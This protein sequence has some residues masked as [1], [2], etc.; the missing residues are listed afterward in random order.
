[1]FG[2]VPNA[3][4]ARLREREPM[5]TIRQASGVK[6]Y[7]PAN[8]KSGKRR[9]IGSVRHVLFHPSENRVVGFAVERANIAMMIEMKD[10]FVALDRVAFETAE[11]NRLEAHAEGKG[12][13]DASA[14]KRLAIDWE[15]SIVW[16]GMPVATRSGATLGTVRDAVFD[17]KTGAINAVGLTQGMT[18]DTAIGVRDLPAKMVVGFDAEAH[19]VVLTDDAERIE[20]DGGAAAAAGKAAAVAK[21]RTEQATD[22]ALEKFDDA[23]VK[24]G[25]AVGKAAY[26]AKVAAKKAA[27][28]ETGKKAIGWLKSLR[29]EVVDAMG[30]PDDD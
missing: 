3:G 8:A 9:K 14:A 15:Q 11:G 1:M 21:V 29:D 18:R 23:A 24:A 28:T 13:W 2:P 7:G 12:A 16:E 5:L 27:Q 10:R 30:D 17:E 19:A 22:V 26:S 6:V 25:A 4:P 20:V